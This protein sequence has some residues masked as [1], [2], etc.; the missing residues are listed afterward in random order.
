MAAGGGTPTARH[1]VALCLVGLS[2]A[3]VTEALYAL[4][5]RRRPR[6]VPEELHIVTTRGGAAAVNATLL[7]PHGA[8]AELRR[9]YRLRSDALRCP[10]HHVHVVV[11]ARSEPLD[12]IVTSADSEAVGEQLAALVQRLG[13]PH[14]T[15]LHCSLAGGRK[16]MGA[17]L[18]M[19]LQLHGGPDDRLYHVLVSPPWER[20]PGFF[21]PTRR[22]QWLRGPDGPVD[23]RRAEVTLAEVPLVRLGQAVRRLGLSGLGLA[24]LAAE[25]EAETAGR[26]H[27][28]P[29]VLEPTH[30]RVRVGD[31]RVALPAQQF[32]LYQLYA[33]ARRRCRHAACRG[34]ARCPGCQLADD[35]VHDR[36]AEF[37]AL[38]RALARS[39]AGVEERR[40]GPASESLE[41][42]RK[43]LEQTRSRLNRTLREALGGPGPR[44][45]SYLV[46]DE[47]RVAGDKRRRGLGL[48]PGL[49]QIVEA[50][51]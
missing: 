4:A 16:T 43:W 22:S 49:V 37:L 51:A 6:V 45:M 23:A 36:R 25:V 47:L 24:R 38:Y 28:D 40:S 14:G 20:V 13:A 48:Q 30:R 11:D 35:E 3:V 34:G 41:E 31:V 12:D 1:I 17:L 7:G 9:N 26:L 15:V 18:A 33:L 29:L 8:L 27:L 39:P 10:P 32:A 50:G 19:A 44:A 2:P 5:V 46:T 42:F 21:F